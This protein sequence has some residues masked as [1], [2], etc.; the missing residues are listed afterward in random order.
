VNGI[1]NILT[2]VQG[3]RQ[4]SVQSSP[5][6]TPIPEIKAPED[7]KTTK[8]AIIEVKEDNLIPLIKEFLG[9][10]NEEAK[11]QTLGEVLEK[12]NGNEQVVKSILVQLIKQSTQIKYID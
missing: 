6:A 2:K 7:M 8:R 4:Q 11:K 3:F 10:I 9:G 5:T 1:N 12:F